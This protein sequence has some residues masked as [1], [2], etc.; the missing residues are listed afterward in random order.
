ML[1]LCATATMPERIYASFQGNECAGTPEAFAWTDLYLIVY[2][3]P[4]HW[5]R[6]DSAQT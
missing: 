4:T 5:S 3:K 1:N 6:K 2:A